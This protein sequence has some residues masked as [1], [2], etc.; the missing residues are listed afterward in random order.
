MRVI[1]FQSPV[2][3]WSSVQLVW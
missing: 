1:W 2:R 3:G